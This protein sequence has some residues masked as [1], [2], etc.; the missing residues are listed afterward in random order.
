MTTPLWKTRDFSSSPSRPG[1]KSKLRRGEI[2]AQE[3]AQAVEAESGLSEHQATDLHHLHNGGSAEPLKTSPEQEKEHLPD[4]RVGGTTPAAIQTD[5]QASWRKMEELQER[6]P[7]ETTR[8]QPLGRTA[9]AKDPPPDPRSFHRPRAPPPQRRP[10]RAPEAR[11]YLRFVRLFNLAP[12]TTFIEI[13]ASLAATAPVG[14]VLD[15]SWDKQ[16][17]VAHRGRQVRGAILL[18]DHDAAPIDLIRLARQKTFRVRGDTVF[19]SLYTARAFHRNVDTDAFSSRVLIL[20]GLRDVDDFS[21]EAITEL[22]MGNSQ[23]VASLGSLGMNAEAVETTDWGGNQR[24]ITWRFFS[25]EKQSRVVMPILRRHFNEQLSIIPGPDPCWNETLYPRSRASTH[26]Y[27]HLGK[28]EKV[29]ESPTSYPSDASTLLSN[30]MRKPA[31]SPEILARKEALRPW[32]DVNVGNSP[33]ELE[34]IQWEDLRFDP[35]GSSVEDDLDLDEDQVPWDTGG[36]E[37][38]EAVT[39]DAF[40][41]MM[42]PDKD[43][44]KPLPKPQP[45]PLPGSKQQRVSAWLRV[46]K[47]VEQKRGNYRY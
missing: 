20:R 9:P 6:D 4:Q 31:P 44:P 5:S 46:Q 28:V 39:P 2:R 10:T 27:R 47:K 34:P 11:E 13:L 35:N 41:K 23:V 1:A 40:E 17:I 25:N 33:A 36:K 45:K 14:R 26:D 7:D 16:G 32:E 12:D 21:A 18:F 42:A 43:R 19:V 15:I 24:M 37:A 38:S 30:R 29:L 8:Y 3:R 22:L